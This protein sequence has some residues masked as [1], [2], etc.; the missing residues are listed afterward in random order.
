MTRDK[1]Q[2]ET[3]KRSTTGAELRKSTAPQ[4]KGVHPCQD[5]L[6]APE[7]PL[8]MEFPSSAGGGQSPTRLPLMVR[9]SPRRGECSTS[10]NQPDPLPFPPNV[11][12]DT[13][14]GPSTPTTMEPPCAVAALPPPMTLDPKTSTILELSQENRQ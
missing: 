6:D 9:H 10:D 2:M 1:T 14:N 7:R 8:E 13:G 4:R 5:V 12:D 3:D 11:E